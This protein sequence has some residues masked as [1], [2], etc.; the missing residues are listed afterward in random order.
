MK[1]IMEKYSVFSWVLIGMLWTCWSCSSPG[2]RAEKEEADSPIRLSDTGSTASCVYLASDEEDRPLVS[3]VELGDDRGKYLYFAFWDEGRGRFTKPEVLQLPDHTAVHEEGMPKIAVKR[4]GSLLVF[5]E[6]SESSPHSRWG[7]SDIRFRQSFD[8]GKTWTSPESVNPEKSKEV[9]A[10]FS[11][12]TRL[13]DGEIGIGWLGTNPDTAMAGRPVLF[14]RSTAEGGFSPPVV[15]DSTACECCRVALTGREDGA[16]VV[17]YRDL[18]PE[19]IRDISYTVS[20]DGGQSFEL[21]Q[22]ISRDQWKVPGCPHNGPS[23][24]SEGKDSYLVWF[25]EG[26]EPGI[27][28]A[29]VDESG[30]VVARG[31]LSGGGRFAQICK[32]SDGFIATAYNEEYRRNDQIYSRIILSGIHEFGEQPKELSVGEVQAGYPVLHSLG[33]DGVLVAW[34]EEAGIFYRKTVPEGWNKSALFR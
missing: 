30:E 7:V 22:D 2:H 12:I 18:W 31:L 14:A 29:E 32:L 27:R 21:P 15:V 5:Y 1:E 34:R 10:S 26:T 4:D 6:V 13:A 20:V 33:E 28:F 3:W 25:S 23:V 24:I 11:G 9:S 8:K 16:I 19:D 17:A